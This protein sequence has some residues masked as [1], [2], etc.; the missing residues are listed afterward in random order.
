[1]EQH[2]FADSIF[3][4]DSLSEVSRNVDQP[5]FDLRD[6]ETISEDIEFFEDFGDFQFTTTEKENQEPSFK[7]STDTLLLQLILENQTR[8]LQ[9]LA[10]IESCL[11]NGRE[12]PETSPPPCGAFQLSHPAI[13]ASMQ[14]AID[15][16]KPLKYWGE[17]LHFVLRKPDLFKDIIH[18]ADREG[19]CYWISNEEV[20][21]IILATLKGSIP[22][23]SRESMKSRFFVKSLNEN[24]QRKEEAN[25]LVFDLYENKKPDYT[26]SSL[27]Y[28]RVKVE[29]KVKMGR[30]RSFS[31]DDEAEED[32]KDV[33][34]YKL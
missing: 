26:P 4:Y 21:H 32:T 13:T 31:E 11:K 14:E 17:C 9:R 15:A 24:A 27:H 3:A 23:R 8:M 18:W 16:A 5:H 29:K 6:S 25:G 28:P 30:K 10:A 34:K 19:G 2:L 33:K 1:M 22:Q 12:S 20:L 7:A